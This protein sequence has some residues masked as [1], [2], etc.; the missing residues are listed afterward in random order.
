[1][2]TVGNENNIRK[3]SES[4]HNG[5]TAS[6][7]KDQGQ[8]N[9]RIEGQYMQSQVSS[10]SWRQSLSSSVRT[11]DSIAWSP[12]G[13]NRD[14]DH[15]TSDMMQKILNHYDTP[16]REIDASLKAFHLESIILTRSE[17]RHLERGEGNDGS[18]YDDND[19]SL[20]DCGEIDSSESDMTSVASDDVRSNH[21]EAL[22]SD[23]NDD[24]LPDCGEIESSESDKECVACDDVR[25]NYAEAL[26]SNDND[27]AL[28]DCGEIE[29]SESDKECVACDDVRS[30]YAE[31]LQSN[32][33]DDSLAD[34]GEIESS[35]SDKA[36]VASDDVR[37]PTSKVEDAALARSQ[38]LSKFDIGSQAAKVRRHISVRRSSYV[39]N[40]K[41][42]YKSSKGE[43]QSA[44]VLK[45]Y[46]DDSH[47]QYYDIRLHISGMEKQTTGAH[48][49]ALPNKEKSKSSKLAQEIRRERS[50]RPLL[51]WTKPSSPTRRV[52]RKP[53]V[54]RRCNSTTLGNCVSPSGSRLAKG[55]KSRSDGELS[56]PQPPKI[57]SET[58]NRSNSSWNLG[59]L[60]TSLPSRRARVD[61]VQSSNKVRSSVQ[62]STTSQQPV[63]KPAGRSSSGT[64]PRSLR[65]SRSR[66][67]RNNSRSSSWQSKGSSLDSAQ[68]KPLR[69]S[70]SIDQSGMVFSLRHIE[71]TT[72]SKAPSSK[73]SSMKGPSPSRSQSCST[74][75]NGPV[76]SQG[77]RQ[78]RHDN[79]EPTP[80]QP[81]SILKKPTKAFLLWKKAKR[82]S[83]LFP[84]Q[85]M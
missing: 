22:R 53:R 74:L 17:H 47:A 64:K 60:V 29:S 50:N 3:C 26:P 51:P 32:N 45:V 46:R 71:P 31:A 34:C 84:R 14:K 57:S 21:A 66:S 67:N 73:E 63:V 85:Q 61:L 16:R 23:D 8:F 11:F 30:N 82:V 58:T 9:R 54:A 6:L 69:R 5:L 59:T 41:V 37:S 24:S 15:H 65:L 80:N 13:D 1:M 33:N 62:H 77:N 7:G 4:D 81:T 10:S 25:S 56:L 19:D 2:M 76:A 72:V 39:E 42:L 18:N 44:T 12:D 48:L 49:T 78:T 35:E 79:C 28:A 20:P 70:K 40:E 43:I 68:R 38:K 55:R 52:T 75:P 36:C 27:D 83:T